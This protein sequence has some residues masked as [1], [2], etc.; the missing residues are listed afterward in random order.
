MS[1]IDVSFKNHIQLEVLVNA[2]GRV[3]AYH[4][5]YGADVVSQTPYSSS[6]MHVFPLRKSGS[7]RVRVLIRNEDGSTKSWMSQPQRF[8]DLPEPIASRESELAIVGISRSSAFVSHVLSRKRSVTSFVD[9]TGEFVGTHFFGIPVLHEAPAG[10]LLVGHENLLANI[11]LDETYS[12]KSGATD[13]LARELHTYGAMDLYRIS[14][15]A[16]LE[17]FLEGAYHIQG[18]IFNKFNSR[19]PFMAVIGEGTQLG[20]GGIGAV[21]HPEAVIGKNCVI[22]QNVTLGSRAG[23]NG[24]PIVGDN[25][26]IAPGA[27][28]LGGRIGDNV[29][30]GANAVVIDNIPDNCVVAGVPAKIISSDIK[31]YWNY[32]PRS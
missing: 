29:I 1:D 31:K 10:S 3:F 9:P 13:I 4:L 11:G 16:Y 30:I 32:T 15:A 23:G 19:V 17:G 5:Y 25:V 8:V 12:L 21:I 14:R 2:P 18:F 20:I 26:F 22:A 27:K 6:R 28:C 24:T 7:Y